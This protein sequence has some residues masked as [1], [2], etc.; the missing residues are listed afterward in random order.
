[1]T[2]DLSSRTLGML[3]A[4]IIVGIGASQTAR[5]TTAAAPLAVKKWDYQ[6]WREQVQHGTVTE[7][8]ELDLMK[9]LRRGQA[10]DLKDA[11]NGGWELA[12]ITPDVDGGDTQYYDYIFKRP[13]P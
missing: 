8:A 4:G 6:I 10:Q 2:I 13:R 3:L 11:S 5:S 12:A 1:M 9:V 7:T